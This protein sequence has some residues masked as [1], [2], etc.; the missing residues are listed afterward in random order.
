MIIEMIVLNDVAGQVISGVNFTRLREGEIAANIR[1]VGIC[2]VSFA[3]TE[4]GQLVL[5]ADHHDLRAA[6]KTEPPRRI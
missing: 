2:S 3:D 6:A 4:C 1:Y 5:K